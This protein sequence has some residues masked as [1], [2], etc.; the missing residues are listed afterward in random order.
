[1]DISIIIPVYNVEK[2]LNR[3]L[4]SLFDQNFSG[5][6]EVIAVDDCSTDN[7]L[8]LLY[9]YQKKD[10]RLKI[11]EHKENLKLSIVRATGMNIAKGKYIMHLDSDDWLLNNT[12]ESLFRKCIET[13]ADVIVFNL[14]KENIK[15]KQVLVQSIKEEII[16]E[17]KFEIQKYFFGASVNKIVKRSLTNDMLYGKIGINTTED[18]LYATEILLRADRICLIPDAFYIYFTNEESITQTVNPNLLIQNQVI[19]LN[20]INKIALKYNADLGLINNIL[21]YLELS[22]FYVIFKTNFLKTEQIIY[23]KE[24]IDSF[25]IFPQMTKKRLDR[26]ILAMN[27]RYYSFVQVLHHYGI[28]SI[29][30]VF[31]QSIRSHFFSGGVKILFFQSLSRNNSKRSII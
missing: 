9:K 25:K 24:L 27:N 30:F 13:D 3:C 7:S 29:V 22:I 2:Y 6:F 15:G 8:Q 17:D 23:N 4:E 28:K 16:T 10:G 12:L 14:I 5:T 19:I 1:M 20:E 21:I 31:N 11:I 26:L 18:L